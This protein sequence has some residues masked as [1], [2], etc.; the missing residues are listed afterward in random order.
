MSAFP[1]TRPGR[2][3]LGGF[4][5]LVA[6]LLVA[7]TLVVVPLSFTDKQSFVF[8]PTGWSTR[9]YE[10]LFTD[11]SWIDATMLSLRVGGIVTLVATVL[12]TAAALALVMG[13]GR[14]RPPSRGFLLAPTIIPGVIVAIGIF[15]VFLTW[16]LT[17]T[18][19]GF[20][21]AHT[22]LAIPM[23]M[24]AVTASL[25]G[26]DHQL[27]RAAQSLGAGP[28]SAFRQV[29]LPL[30][31]PGVLTGALFAFLTSFDEAIVSLF[32]SGPF[33]RTLPVQ[34]YQSVTAEIDPTIAAA[35]TML[36]TITT[37]VLVVVAL[38]MNSRSR[39]TR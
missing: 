38:I 23:V 33:A 9:W 5:G 22:A 26:F 3:L 21:L 32:I 7:P 15:S 39:R 8:P 35:S 13:R 27:L 31:A 2:A 28:L 20:V 11:Q 29:T 30:I 25:S 14:W 34:I 18:T 17:Q 12:G 16:G 36:V 37:I 10:N 24:I 19:T 4:C 6:V 1:S